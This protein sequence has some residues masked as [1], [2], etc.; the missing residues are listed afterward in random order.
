MP[1]DGGSSS[2]P[3][4]AF[5]LAGAQSPAASARQ[6]I[7]FYCSSSEDDDASSSLS[8][9]ELPLS[10]S[11]LL[12]IKRDGGGGWTPKLSRRPTRRSG[13]IPRSI[14]LAVIYKHYRPSSA[15]HRSHTIQIPL[16]RHTKS[17]SLNLAHATHA[18]Q[19]TMHTHTTHPSHLY[20]HITSCPSWA[21][22]S[23]AAA[24]A[25]AAAPP[26]RRQTA[27]IGSSTPR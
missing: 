16:A 22:G 23:L 2:G 4:A 12:L 10:S 20:L 5:G 15:I 6:T 26:A 14:T 21:P 24:P 3:S 13:R 25:P 11:L 8:S 1:G 17:D 19:I 18:H 7:D 27:G 9:V